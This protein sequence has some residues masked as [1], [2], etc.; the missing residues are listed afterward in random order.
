[1]G[2]KLMKCCKPEQVGTKGYGKML[3]RIV[4]EDSS[5]P[6]KGGQRTGRLKRKREKSREKSVIGS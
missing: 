4:L 1:M 5:V 3:K 2:R 6:A